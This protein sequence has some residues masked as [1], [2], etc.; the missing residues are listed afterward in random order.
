MIITDSPQ[1]LARGVYGRGMK[2]ISG[3]QYTASELAKQFGCT[4][5]TIHNH[6]VKLFGKA[7][8]G[9]TREFDETQVTLLLESVKSTSKHIP[10]T[11]HTSNETLKTSIQGVETELT[12]EY[13]LAVLYRKRAELVEEA[14]ELERRLREKAEA[15]AV[16]A[17]AALGHLTLAHQDTLKA[18]TM[19]WDIAENAGT[20][21][22]DRE[23]MLSFY[24]R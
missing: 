17:E 15:R 8:N 11:G 3:K 5:K 18:N 22:S 13:R 4:T 14:N 12:D 23:D 16:K 24:R 1:P 7:K 10:N 9:V 19:L 20:L 21:T 2:A 6:A